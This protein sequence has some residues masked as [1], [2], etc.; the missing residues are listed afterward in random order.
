MMKNTEGRRAAAAAAGPGDVAKPGFGQRCQC[1]QQLR[2]GVTRD[3]GRSTRECGQN[4]AFRRWVAGPA[5]PQ[6]PAVH[7]VCE[8]SQSA[9]LGRP[10]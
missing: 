6:I 9:P 2:G 1:D 4:V 7:P 5:A 3:A 10:V 8:T